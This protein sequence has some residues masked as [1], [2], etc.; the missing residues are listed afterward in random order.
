MINSSLFNSLMTEFKLCHFDKTQNRFDHI[1]NLLPSAQLKRVVL[2]V[3][4]L[5]NG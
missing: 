3:E 5:Q 4:T 1:L 2:T